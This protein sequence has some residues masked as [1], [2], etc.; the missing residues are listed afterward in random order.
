MRSREEV[1]DIT[2]IHIYIDNNNAKRYKLF[3]NRRRKKKG[4]R[5]REK[6]GAQ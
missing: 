6:C 4:E 5:E 1:L 2:Y 3:K